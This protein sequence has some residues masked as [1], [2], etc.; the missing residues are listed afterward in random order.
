MMINMYI[1]P[2]IYTTRPT[3]ERLAKELRC[4]DFLDSLGVKYVRV[5]HEAAM[6]MEA[7]AK[8]KALECPCLYV[9]I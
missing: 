1:D 3:N 2:T 9:F 4:Y 6:T 5:D 7:C 8:A